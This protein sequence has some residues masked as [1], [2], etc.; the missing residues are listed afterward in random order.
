MIRHV[1]LFRTCSSDLT[2]F[3]TVT[4]VANYQYLVICVASS[5]P[6]SSVNN[7]EQLSI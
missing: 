6:F 3:V 5:Y 1:F 7:F 4:Y 2:Y